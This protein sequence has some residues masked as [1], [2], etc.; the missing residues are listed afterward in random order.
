MF[1]FIAGIQPKTIDL[2]THPRF[3]RSCGL[4]QARIKRIDHYLSLFFLP[5]LRLKKG[6][7]FL[8]CGSC[9]SIFDESGEP[10]AEPPKSP[11][12][13]CFR[14][15]NPLD[16][17]FRFCPSCGKAVEGGSRLVE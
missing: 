2:D 17:G 4:Y 16:P 11:D 14:C 6:D 3:C 15:G 8:Q 7:P 12:K 10:W 5:L 9:G 13:R 1:F